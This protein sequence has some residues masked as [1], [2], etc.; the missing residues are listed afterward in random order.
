M[1]KRVVVAMG[2]SAI[3]K[4]NQKPEFDVQMENIKRNAEEIAKIEAMDYEVVLTHGNVPQVGNILRKNEIAK[5]VVPASPLDAC[6]GESQG[7]IGYMLEQS[8]K[9]VLKKNRS[10]ANVVTL[11]TEVEVDLEDPVF[12]N[13]SKPIGIFYSEEQAKYLRAKKNWVMVEN[14]DH[15]YR[16]VVPSPN[17]S[18]IHGVDSVI[19][20]L[21]QNNIVIAAGGGGIPVYQTEDG[22]LA[23][24]EAV[25]DKDLTG[26]KLAEQV[27]AD[28]FMILTDESTVSVKDNRNREKSLRD[29]SVDEAQAY[30][31]SGQIISERMKSKVA[32]GIEFAKIGGTSIICALDEAGLALEGKVGTHINCV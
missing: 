24:V 25:I 2:G 13:P 5:D 16:R 14:K 31:Q 18:M 28:I 7:Y 20:L 21:E 26:R 12:E 17:P 30:L 11:L 27:G 8:L 1:A 23:G 29:V 32:A 19:H 6:N 22:F 9:N 4:H 10:S 15:G 3:L